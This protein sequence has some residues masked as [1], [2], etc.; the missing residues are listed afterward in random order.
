[1][2]NV[3]DKIQAPCGE[4]IVAPM[5]THEPRVVKAL[6][7]GTVA[8]ALLMALSPAAAPAFE[9]ELEAYRQALSRIC[10]TGVTPEVVRLYQAAVTALE[11]P[12]SQSGPQPPPNYAG[13][14]PPELAYSD[15][16]QGR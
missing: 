6:I 4:E 12:R 7:A 5:K 14:R 2:N 3:V 1:M 11:A 9:A 15:C 8:A 13:L 10:K 16:V